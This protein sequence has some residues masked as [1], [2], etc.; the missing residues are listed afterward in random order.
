MSDGSCLRDALSQLLGYEVWYP[1]WTPA[2]ENPFIAEELG[3]VWIDES[4]EFYAQ[5]VV[6]SFVSSE[7]KAHCMFVP[8]E[9]LDQFFQWIGDRSILGMFIRS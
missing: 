7:N 1:D 5:D 4:T 9:S 8:A 6:F 2:T 3:L